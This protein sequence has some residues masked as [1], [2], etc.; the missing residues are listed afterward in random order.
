MRV[1]PAAPLTELFTV[2]RSHHQRACRAVQGIMGGTQLGIHVGNRL[3]ILSQ[4]VGLLLL[5]Q[6]LLLVPVVVGEL[7]VVLP[8]P[9]PGFVSKG[10]GRS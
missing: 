5:R 1:S 7:P 4:L 8:V 10:G 3:V 2:I 9:G 6:R